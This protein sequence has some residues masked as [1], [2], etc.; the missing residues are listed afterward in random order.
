MSFSAGTG[1]SV[2]Q[3]L[4]SIG[5]RCMGYWS[6]PTTTYAFMESLTRLCWRLFHSTAKGYCPLSL[7][8][9]RLGVRLVMAVVPQ[10]TSIQESRSGGRNFVG[11]SIAEQSVTRGVAACKVGFGRFALTLL[12]R[13]G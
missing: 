11:L 6:R 10:P 7:R 3:R 2:S 4:V 1:T 5:V 12:A 9:R 13:G 8:V